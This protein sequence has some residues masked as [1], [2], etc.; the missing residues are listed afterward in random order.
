M[1]NDSRFIKIDGGFE[2]PSLG[3]AMTSGR[4]LDLSSLMTGVQ[5]G[6]A[7]AST[8]NSTGGVKISGQTTQTPGSSLPA[9]GSPSSYQSTPNATPTDTS[10]PPTTQDTDPYQAYLKLSQQLYEKAKGVDTLALQKKIRDLNLAQSNSTRLTPEEVGTMSPQQQS[11]LETTRANSFTPQINE[12]NYELAKAQKAVDNF[13][14]VYSDAQKFNADYA[15][16]MEAPDSTIKSAQEIVYADPDKLSIVLSSLNDKSKQKFWDTIDHAKYA[17]A[18]TTK[19]SGGMTAPEN[20]NGEFGSTIDQIANMETTVAGNA[21][22]RSQLQSN[23]ANKDYASAYNQI[24]NS[25]EST[26]TGTP[27][28]QFSSA[29][30]DF[31]VMQGL[32]N[33]IKTYSE[34]GGNMGLLTGTEEQIKRKLG[35]DSGKASALATQLWRE[36]HT[37]RNTMTGAAFTPE[38]SRDYASVNPTLGK[39]LDLNLSVIDGALS[40]LKNRVDSTITAR[41]PSA[42]YIKDYAEGATAPASTTLQDV[43]EKNGVKYQ[44]QPD[45]SYKKIS[46]SSGGAATNRPQSNNNPL[47]LKASAFTQSFPGVAGLD[48][49]L[50]SDGGKFLVFESPEA[51]LA[52]AQKLLTSNVYSGLSVDAALR[53]WSGG[54]YGAEIAPALKGKTIASLSPAELSTLI[55]T[56]AKREGYYA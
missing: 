9:T 27:K 54:G 39:S 2:R 17:G 26:L 20:Y 45:G 47:N 13:A 52:G 36:F 31:Q 40:Q 43:M 21:R 1:A 15:E 19:N 8:P 32:E 33:A 5:P 7:P 37:Y 55:Q 18:V 48:P 53:K 4:A 28:Q 12:A 42:K 16:K 49:K 10:V 11:D 34:A 24:A 38:E 29:R 44:K 23:I 14:Q 35:I 50:A 25:V 22:V 30:T 51:G 46:F 56:M 41:V 6:S 3:S